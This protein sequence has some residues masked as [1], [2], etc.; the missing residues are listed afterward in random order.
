VTV[1]TT[2]PAAADARARRLRAP[3][4]VTLWALLAIEAAGGLVIFFARLAAGATPGV[5][6]HVVAGLALVLAWAAY[7]WTHWARVAPWRSRLDYTL[8]L[9]AATSMALALATG[10]ALAPAWWA[11]RRAADADYAAWLSGA[12]NVMSMFV[13]TFAAAHLLAVL[14]R[15]SRVRT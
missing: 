15:A 13:L 8:G 1:A 2:R 7:Q 4:L 14:Q 6:L 12:H 10:L 11:A 3:L 5:T 9:I